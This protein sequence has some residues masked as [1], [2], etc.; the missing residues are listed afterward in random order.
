MPSAS[1]G[2]TPST[3]NV[4]ATTLDGRIKAAWANY[5]ERVYVPNEGSG[6][7]TV[8]DPKRFKVVGTYWVGFFPEHVTPDWD[9]HALYV[10]DALS[11]SLARFDPATGKPE[12]H[13]KVPYPYNLYFTPDGTRAIDVED[14]SLGSA[15]DDNGLRFFD[16]TT[17]TEVGFLPIR[18]AGANHL[19]FT[20]DGSHLILSCEYTGEIVLVDVARMS[21]VT[22]IHVGGSPTD[23]RLSP[24]GN[25]VF[26]ANQ[27]RNVVDVLDPT[28][29]KRL[30]SIRLRKGAHG[31]A[32]SRDT[33]RLFVTDRLS[34]RLSVVD[35]ATL[36]VT[37]TWVIGGSPD[38]IAQSPDGSQLW[39]SNRFTNT[40][41]VVDSM[42]GKV[43]K[44]IVVGSRPHGLSYWPLPG[45]FSLGHN[46][47]MR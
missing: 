30:T 18:W 27:V 25:M 33:T 19:D 5:P 6:T 45:E 44:T 8:I 31:L 46:G 24:N 9:G 43:L 22:A 13:I 14:G 34:G 38:M 35:L 23:V 47:N 16:R 15:P 39:I 7:V 1:P 17:W 21:V 11:S 26:V 12:G 32:I 2:P 4:Y 37:A 20:A 3:T 40:V 42:S 29:L 41:T 36:K 10:E 28:T